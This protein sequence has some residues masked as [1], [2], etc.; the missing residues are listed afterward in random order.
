MN[1]DIIADPEQRTRKARGRQ[2]S[3]KSIE[4]R[5]RILE[6]TALQ[7]A[8]KGYAETRLSDIADDVGIHLSALY[9]HFD[10]KEDLTSELLSMV[11]RATSDALRDA[12]ANLP[13]S[14]RHR[15]RIAAAI[16]V[17]LQHI[18]Q[19]DAYTRASLQIAQQAPREVREKAMAIT[20]QESETLKMLL[21]AARADGAVRRDI[22]LTMA[23]MVLFGAM[24]WSVEWFKP[25]HATAEDFADEVV[26]IMFDGIGPDAD[27]Q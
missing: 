22:D 2:P 12:L 5:T 24:N 8:E 19:Q 4:T 13:P 15:D 3:R 20:R 16:K 25:G 18:L 27:Q 9:Y 11:P 6:V 21:E 26:K 1:K 10:T 14:A 17:H 7:I 23:R